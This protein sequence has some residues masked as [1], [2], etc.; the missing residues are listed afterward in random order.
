MRADKANGKA[1][2]FKG[3]V[4]K[5]IAC[6]DDDP[7]FVAALARRLS[8]LS[9][10]VCD[11]RSLEDYQSRTEPAR[12]D[13]VLVDLHMADSS[14]VIWRFAGFEVV[15]AIR[16]TEENAPPIVVVTG[17]ANA[18]LSQSARVNGAQGY[19]EKDASLDR[20]V[21]RVCDYVEGVPAQ[22][23]SWTRGAA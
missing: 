1:Q 12:P 18:S 10:A 20:T 3:L 22:A 7:V 21:R 8:H 5:V 23:A 16:A 17:H 4:M 2:R 9:I 13:L 6:I 15:R 11:F 19:I 14:G